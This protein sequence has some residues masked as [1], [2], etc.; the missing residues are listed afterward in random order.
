M[1]G[2]FIV[3]VSRHGGPG[4]AIDTDGGVRVSLFFFFRIQFLYYAPLSLGDKLGACQ[5][6]SL[7]T[8]VPM[9]RRSRRPTSIESNS[10]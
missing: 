2:L 9:T 1:Q 5:L 3:V 6:P 7:V 10:D 8:D 4:L